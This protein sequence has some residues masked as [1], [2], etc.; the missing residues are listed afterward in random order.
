[1]EAQE[2]ETQ[3]RLLVCRSTAVDNVEEFVEFWSARYRYDSDD[4]YDKNIGKPLT[5]KRVLDLF[6]WKNGLPLSAEKQASVTNNFVARLDV[7]GVKGTETANDLL[8][9]FPTGGAIW[10]IFWLHCIDRT[11]FPIYDQHVHRA[12]RFIQGAP[13]EIPANAKKKLSTYQDDYMPFI[14]GLQAKDQ[15]NLD[16]ALW[17]FGK[18][19]SQYAFPWASSEV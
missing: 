12:M 3:H 9:R 14:R 4:L 15:R 13:G 17:A 10:R 16:K 6:R 8:K 19:L 7:V 1:M 5:Q 18:F 2:Q 11:R